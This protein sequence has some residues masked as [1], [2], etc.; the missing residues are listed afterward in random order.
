VSIHCLLLCHRISFHV[1]HGTKNGYSMAPGTRKFAQ[2]LWRSCRSCSSRPVWHWAP[3]R[4]T[5][6]DAS[7]QAADLESVYADLQH[8]GGAVFR[9]SPKESVVR[10]YAF[11]GGRAGRA[12]HNHVLSAPQFSGF[13]YLPPNGAASGRFDLAFRLDQLELDDPAKRATLGPAFSS[14]LTPD[15]IYSTR[16]HLLGADGLQADRFPWVRIRS[17]QISGEAP[18]FAAKIQIE[19]HGEQRN[20]W[21]PLNVDQLS[22]RL[23]ASGSLVLRQSDFGVRPYSL[24]GGFL[25]VQ[26]EVVVD[27]KLTGARSG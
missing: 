21:V 8:S 20:Q 13:F 15:D 6:F 19:L 27:F 25:S 22:D 1:F 5:A 10:I 23:S 26:D 24:L 14:V 11:R 9:L 16:A 7:P 4:A 17:L 2:A 12:G 18:K 3:T